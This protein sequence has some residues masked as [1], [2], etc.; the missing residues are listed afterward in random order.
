M[1]VA[2]TTINK[3]VREILDQLVRDLPQYRWESMCIHS[4]GLGMTVIE[5][6]IYQAG[7]SERIGQIAYHLETGDILNHRYR[8][9]E[10]NAPESILDLIL[11]VVN[12]ER[13]RVVE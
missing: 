10:G 6:N 5:I 2:P 8:G 12:L 7:G 3:A 4:D 13:S 1:S 9:Y 11:D